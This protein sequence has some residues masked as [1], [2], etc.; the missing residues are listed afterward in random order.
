MHVGYIPS[1]AF[2]FQ[3]R[4][5]ILSTSSE[6]EGNVELV[7]HECCTNVPIFLSFSSHIGSYMIILKMV[8]CAAAHAVIALELMHAQIIVHIDIMDNNAL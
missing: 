5:T 3:T 8:T 4:D 7:L 2:L 6:P 1:N